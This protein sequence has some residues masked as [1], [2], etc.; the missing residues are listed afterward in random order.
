MIMST[1]PVAE[2]IRTNF[3][4]MFE[5]TFQHLYGPGKY[6]HNWHHDYLARVVEQCSVDHAG[7][8]RCQRMRWALVEPM[9]SQAGKTRIRKNAAGTEILEDLRI[10]PPTFSKHPRCPPRWRNRYSSRCQCG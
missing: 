1:A 10:D 3:S 2:I 4:A 6:Q 5:M 7:T 8:G 9:H